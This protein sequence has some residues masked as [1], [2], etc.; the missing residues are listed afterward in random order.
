MLQEIIIAF[1]SY[2]QAH[3]LI[4]KYK[5]WKWILFTGIIYTLLFALGLYFFWIYSNKAVHYIFNQSGIMAWLDSMKQGWLYLLV[6]VGQL[7]IVGIMFFIFFS[8]FKVLFLIVGSPIFAYLSEK[9]ESIISGKVFE[10]NFPRLLKDMWRAIKIAVRNFLWQMVYLLAILILS[11]IPVAGWIAPLVALLTE[12]YFF[13]FSMLDYTSERKQLSARTSIEL[14]RRHK[15]LAIGNGL[16][17]YL[18]HLV[19]VIGWLFAP[20]YA[21]IAATLSLN[22][23]SEKN[24]VAL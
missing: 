22:K 23:A 19:P 15:G 6:I 21:V 14:I 8:V 2:I 5:M 12:C 16:V 18:M 7:I 1:Q 9:T 10:F 11:F 3:N 20:S 13:G 4:K 17:F 24:I